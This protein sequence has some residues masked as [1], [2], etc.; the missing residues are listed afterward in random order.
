MASILDKLSGGDL[1]SIGKSNEVIEQVLKN[2]ALFG[3][4]FSGMKNADPVIRARAADAVEKVSRLH[5]EYLQPFKSKIIREIAPISQQEVRW[6]VAQ[7][8]SYLNLTVL[9]K[10]KIIDLLIGWLATE[11][12][13]KIV[14]VNCLQTL[15]NFAQSDSKLKQRILKTLHF[16]TQSGSPALI[17][18]SKKLL[19]ELE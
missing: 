8:F 16:Y 5:P 7:M 13:S 9:E 6:H 18:R 14:K 2:P 12:K 10:S 3:E 15:A 4:L 11:T 1:R 19:Y 17:S